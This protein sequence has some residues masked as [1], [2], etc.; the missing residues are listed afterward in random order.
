MSLEFSSL[1][2]ETSTPASYS[3]DPIAWALDRVWYGAAADERR[4]AVRR[5]GRG[6]ISVAT[7]PAQPLSGTTS[8]HAWIQ[9]H[10]TSGRLIDLSMTGV[11]MMLTRPLEPGTAILVRLAPHKDG[12]PM[13]V[14]AEV[15]R[16]QELVEG[17]WKIVAKFHQHLC[18][19]QAYIMTQPGL[20]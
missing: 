9:D 6:D 7:V 12:S 20:T 15:V 10:G 2:P 17:Q 18:F 8:P 11:S 3:D 5:D 16:S 19:D 4:S 14:P 1:L 13:D